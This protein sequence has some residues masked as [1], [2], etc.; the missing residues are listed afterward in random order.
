MM[1]SLIP[2]DLIIQ[3]VLVITMNPLAPFAKG[4]AISNGKIAGLLYHEEEKWPLVPGGR[5]IDGNGMT[6][7]PGLIEAHCHL[8]AQISCDLSVACGRKEV[9]NISDIITIIQKRADRLPVGTWIRATGYDPFYQTDQRHPTRWDLDKATTAHPVRLRHVTRHASVLNSM[10]LAIA[11]IGPDTPDP[12]GVTV[13]REAGTGNPTGLIYGGDAWLSRHVIPPLAESDLHFGSKQLQTMLLSKGITA[14]QDATP[15]NTVGDLQFWASRMEDG[16]CLPL[17]LMAEEERHEQMVNFF[18]KELSAYFSG[19]LE[20]GPVKVVM[21][22]LPHLWP[23][24]HELS[25]LASKTVKRGS[26]LAIHVVNPEMVWAA[27]EAIR[28]VAEISADRKIKHRL[29]HLSLCP[30]AFLPDIA[31][32]GIMV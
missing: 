13:V 24:P 22:A 7:M 15:T 25:K 20:M 27:I 2:A 32:L 1:P 31:E 3:N 16:W 17:Q 11:G 26:S 29:E 18:D 9:K 4:I 14:V 28:P 6:L 21:E 23:E 30:E 19:R 12:P 8:R 5:Y 10:A